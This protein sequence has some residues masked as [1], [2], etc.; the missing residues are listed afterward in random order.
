MKKIFLIISLIFL[1]S[2]VL[3]T[4][5]ITNYLVPNNVALNQ[6]LTI[7]GELTSTD[8]NIN[9]ILCAFYIFDI[10]NTDLNQAII[11]LTDQPTYT[12]GSF[13]TSITITE[14]LFRR[15]IDYNAITKC[16]SSEI[17]K[18]FSITQKEDIEFG[19]IPQSLIMDFKFFVE[20]QN[21]LVVAILGFFFLIGIVIVSPLLFQLFR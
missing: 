16:R 14:P 17:G 2:N 20:P 10:K 8:Q 21:S 6:N 15:G 11:R 7:Y 13:Y 3:A 18:V 5:S 9:N 1:I 12:D 4:D 19:I